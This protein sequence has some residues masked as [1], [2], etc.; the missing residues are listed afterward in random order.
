[1]ISETLPSFSGAVEWLNSKPLTSAD[2]QGKVVVV[3]FWTYTC[4]NWLR[5]LPYVRAWADKY[6]DKGLM[7]IGVHTPEFSIERNLDNIRSAIKEMRIGYPVAVDSNYAI[8]NAF[9]NQYWPALYIIDT[10]GRI[11]YHH[12]GEGNY[13]QSEHAIQEL[14]TEA[15]NRGIDSELVT[16]DPRGLEVAA[17]WNDVRSPENFLGYERTEG[18]A[19]PGGIVQ[20]SRHTY[21]I[22]ERLG[23]N[24]WGLS[25]EWAMEQ[26]GVVSS[27]AGGKIAYRFHARDV[28]LVMGPNTRG[29]AVRF[30]VLID[31][32]PPGSAR[33][34]DVDQNGYGSVSDQRTYQLIRQSKPIIDRQFEIEFLEPSVE[35]F[36]FTFG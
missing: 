36:D 12:F 30:R 3:Q 11:R 6:K 8:W 16:V 27:V 14:L 25:G 31:G 20:N 13:E 26:E 15:G 22:P 17:D 28:N 21:E 34:G 33:G 1:M 2:L 29:T 10:H 7:V 24:K 35:A 32:Q 19:S 5:T 9:D 4:V 23:L 18:F